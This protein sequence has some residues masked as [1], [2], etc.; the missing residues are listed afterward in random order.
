MAREL[1]GQKSVLDVLLPHLE[2]V[3][4]VGSDG[5]RPLQLDF[6]RDH[7]LKVDDVVLLLL[8]S[9]AL[10]WNADKLTYNFG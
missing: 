2:T 4:S 10:G 7:I 8:L 3:R 5:A 9:A 6:G 1:A